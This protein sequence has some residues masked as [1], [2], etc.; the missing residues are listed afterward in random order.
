MVQQEKNQPTFKD[1]EILAEASQL[2][3]VVDLDSV[4]HKVISLVSRAVGAQNISLFLHDGE[5]VN[6]DHLITMRNLSL[7]K[8]IKVVRKVLTEGFAGWVFRN[9]KGDIIEDT[10][11][12][13]RW[14]IFPD[15]PLQ[16]GSAMCIPFL[17]DDEVVAIITLT[18]PE[19]YHFRP[20]HLRLVEIIANQVTVAIRNSQLVNNLQEQGRQQHA[21]L[22]AI[23]DVLLVLD[24]DG[25]IVLVNDTA[26]PLLDVHSHQEVEG[27]NISEFLMVDDAF[28][29]IVE[30]LESGIGDTQQ[31]NFETRSERFQTDYQV[32]M[33]IW[34]GSNRTLGYV[35][36]M[37]NVTPIHDLARFKDEMLR[38]ATHD[39]RSPLALVAGYAAMIASDTPDPDSPVHEYVEIIK[40][41]SEK[42]SNLVDDLLRV[43]R[44]RE[45]P[46]ELHEKTDMAALVKLV[47]VNA[48]PVANAKSI[49]LESDIRLEDMRRIVTDPVLIR[50]A[51]ENFIYNAIKYTPEYGVVKVFAYYDDRRFHFTVEDTGIGIPE[52][53]Q[54]YVFES[55]YRV[56]SVKNT[57]KGSGLGLSLV[58]TVITRHQGEVWVKSSE[59]EG[60]RFGFWMPLNNER[61]TLEVE[62]VTV[63]ENEEE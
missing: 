50:Q 33:S 62:V 19:A 27:H 23:A 46:L 60:S 48:R 24:R 20:H 37:H 45:S 43:E 7:D 30:I 15:D 8:S 39:L 40:Q 4:I 35:V 16:T 28:E 17:H 12:D 47:M 32:R 31:W 51:M 22:Q 26:L 34:I 25:N 55:F 58:K 57:Q 61:D 3:T 41:Q 18:H 10:N 2:L 54:A 53:H 63:V 36:V 11:Q 6:W 49:N 1:L 9:K 13:E 42:M 21:I 14:I 59:G 5:Q 52:E 56:D 38:V 44:I 29:P